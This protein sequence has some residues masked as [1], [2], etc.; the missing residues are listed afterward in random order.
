[1]K[2]LLKIALYFLCLPITNYGKDVQNEM[3]K[4]TDEVLLNVK[5]KDTGEIGESLRNLVVSL[6]SAGIDRR[7]DLL[8]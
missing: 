6:D 1:M 3:T 7:M 5:N 8:T 4:F 2:Y